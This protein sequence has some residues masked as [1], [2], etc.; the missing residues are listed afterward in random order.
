LGFGGYSASRGAAIG[1]GSTTMDA[2]G[3]NFL[4]VNAYTAW[5]T[6]SPAQ[7]IGTDWH[8]L[9]VT[10][11]LAGAYVLYLDGTSVRSGTSALHSTALEASPGFRIGVNTAAAPRY[12]DGTVD[13][14][15]LFSSA[16]SQPQIADI[17]TNSPGSH[18]P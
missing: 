8:H 5:L 2:N 18:A 1:Y 12:P 16:L 15:M 13:D 4:A 3:D 6:P 7:A 14:V 10:Y 17:Y 11:S 9:A